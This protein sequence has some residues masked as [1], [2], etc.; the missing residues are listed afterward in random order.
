MS[1]RKWVLARLSV[2]A[3]RRERNDFSRANG[4]TPCGLRKYGHT[5]WLGKEDFTGNS[6]MYM[7]RALTCPAERS[8]ARF[9]REHDK[10]KRE[11]EHRPKG[12]VPGTRVWRRCNALRQRGIKHPL[13]AERQRRNDASQWIHNR[14]DARIRGPHQR[15][16]FLDGSHP[17]LLEM[18]LRSGAE[19]EPAVIGEIEHPGRPLG[20]ARHEGP[21]NIAAEVLVCPPRSLGARHRIAWKDDLVAHQR[22]EVRRARDALIWTSIAGNE[23]APE[24][25]ELP[26]SQTFQNALKR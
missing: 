5:N 23:P 11:R 2:H 22:Q 7:R 24:L 15:Q 10:N 14:R 25:R 3:D 18:L 1:R 12:P 21:T 26:Q 6:G 20:T 17:G 8:L 16:P 13:Y 4:S 19:P 9:A